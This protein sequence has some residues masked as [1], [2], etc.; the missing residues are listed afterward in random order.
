[1]FTASAYQTVIRQGPRLSNPLPSKPLGSQEACL[2]P[3]LP[4]KSNPGPVL[5]YP[6]ANQPRLLPFLSLQPA[7]LKTGP[8][9]FITSRATASAYSLQGQV[10]LLR[11]LNLVNASLVTVT[12]DLRSGL[13]TQ[14]LTSG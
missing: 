11:V 8:Q 13:T 14:I 5:S 1:M 4:E 9:A 2:H 12:S 3:R 7:V 6:A 10:S